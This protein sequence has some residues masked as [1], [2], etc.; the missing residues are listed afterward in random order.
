VLGVDGV[1][2]VWDN[3]QAGVDLLNDAILPS[4]AGDTHDFYVQDPVTS[5]E[6]SVTMTSA[7]VTTDPVPLV[8]TVDSSAGTVGY[9]LFNEHIATAE[10]ELV[11]AIEQLRTAGITELVLDIRYNGGGYLDIASEL[12]YMIAGPA[13]TAGRTFEQLQFNDKHTV[14][15]PVTGR[16]LEPTPFHATTQGF[17]QAAGA[18]LPTLDLGRVHVLTGPDT[19]SASESIVNGLRGIGVEVVQIGGTTCGKPYGFYPA[20]NCGTTYFTVQFQGV[21][22]AGFGAY[23]D[24]FTPANAVNVSGVPVTGCA[25]RDDLD[26]ALGDPAEARFAAAL[27]RMNLGSCP[28]PS[29]S[30][31]RASP[32]EPRPRGT[33]RR[34]LR[35]WSRQAGG[36]VA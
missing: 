16:P 19:C 26:H 13:R 21:N 8:N 24:G 11:A 17:S 12:G 22:D 1:D 25:V 7:L 36:R 23:P 10:S 18:P 14:N 2:A 27:R 31:P 3:T 4:Q 9:L 33:A 5:A 32:H 6:R 35:R 15:N 28:A 30:A 29:S 34:T 20:D